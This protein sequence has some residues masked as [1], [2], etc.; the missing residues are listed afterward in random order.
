MIK[1]KYYEILEI[2]SNST[3]DDIK[4]SYRKLSLLHHP[5]KNG[6]SV[7]SI[8][9]IQ[10]INEAYDVLSD[11]EKKMMYDNESN[12]QM[13]GMMFPPDMPMDFQNILSSMF[14]MN[15][16][17]SDTHTFR[18]F[19]NGN[20]PPNFIRAPP[21]I[22]KT[23]LI[24]FEKVLFN[25]KMPIEIIRFV[26]DQHQRIQETETIYIDIPKGI[27]DSEILVI[28]E[29]GNVI[30]NFRGDV[31]IF[32]KIENNTEFKRV[33]LDLVYNKTITLKES[34]CGFTFELKYLNG[35]TYT[36]T[37]SNTIGHV[38]YQNYQKMIP[39]MG[40]ER[41]NHVGN[42]IIFFNIKFPEQLSEDVLEELKKINF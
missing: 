9:K 11:P 13:N 34:L 27:D 1:K 20:G 28:K 39:N 16:F 36:I 40:L 4:K 5:D 41:D 35:K 17:G 2:E 22:V 7:E 19:C 8:N 25:L 10:D 26:Q 37:N 24:P 42:L 6:N 33:G 21:S 12:G 38:I 23:I 31:K 29:K 3:P 14:Q 32:I 15:D 18:V 30:N